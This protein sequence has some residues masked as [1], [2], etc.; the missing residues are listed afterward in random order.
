MLQQLFYSGINEVYEFVIGHIFIILPAFILSGAI[1]SLVNKFKILKYCGPDANKFVAYFL[2]SVVGVCLTVCACGVVPLFSGIY[3]SGVGIGPAVT[4]LFSGPAIN[5]TAIVLTFLLLGKKM[6]IARIVATFLGAYLIGGIFDMLYGKEKPEIDFKKKPIKDNNRKWW[7]TFLL[8]F[9]LFTLTFI[10]A[11]NIFKTKIK[12]TLYALNYVIVAII[13]Y[14]FLEKD[15][16]ISWM[17]KTKHFAEKIVLP[18]LIGVFFIG[19]FRNWA[20]ESDILFWIKGNTWEA[21]FIASVAAA[22]MYFGSCVSVPF[23]AGLTAL[24]MHHGPALT[25]LLAG[26]AVSLPTFLSIRKVMGNKK[27]FLYLLLVIIYSM[28][29]GKIF[30]DYF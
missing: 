13:A 7:Q 17:K 6:G 25:L 20:T 3:T 29:V 23:V 10:P 11:V 4:F 19:V 18:M 9:F 24:G 12:W 21:N 26:P 2:T 28:I 5:L 16:I 8:F 27:S 15:E 30:G 14:K 22:I 1:G